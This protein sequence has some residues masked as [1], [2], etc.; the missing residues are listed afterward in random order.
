[1]IDFSHYESNRIN[2]LAP[3]VFTIINRLKEEA[4]IKGI[5]VI[6]LGMGSPDLPVHP[7]IREELKK[8]VDERFSNRYPSST[9]CQELKRAISYWYGKRFNVDL[10]PKSEILVLIGSKE[11]IANL[12]SAFLN[13]DDF[14]IAPT[15][16]YP[17]FFNSIIIFGGILYFIP[18]IPE[19][20]YLPQLEN[21]DKNVLRRTKIIYLSYPHNPTGTTV[22]VDYFKEVV[23]FAKKHK[24]IISH[25]NAYSEITFDDYVAPS[26]LQAEGS[27]EVGVEFHSFSKTFSMAGWRIAFVVGN[28]QIISTLSRMKSYVD[29]G[30]F[31]PIQKAA[32][33]ALEL[34]FSEIRKTAQVY[35]ERR[36]VFIEGLKKI[37]WKVEKPKATFYIWA[38]IPEAF[39]EM[40][41]LEFASLL[42]KETG[43]CVAPGSG[44]GEAGDGYVRFA[45]VEEKDRLLEA[46]N[47]LSKL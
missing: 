45:L 16:T 34:P 11:G 25:D 17:I 24:I 8:E 18:L 14:A 31:T 42:I 39:K 41:S 38:P 5:D 19:N 29:F 21:I 1:M 47:R 12:S 37:G 36:D 20:N 32:V 27:K 43:V 44:F 30:V 6:D 7:A 22:T 3:Y 28:K 33:K 9:G 4:Y 40:N 15:P 13:R 2:K 23:E 10:D 35:Q 46:I 26:F